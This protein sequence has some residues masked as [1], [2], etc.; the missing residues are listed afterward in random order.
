MTPPAAIKVTALQLRQDP[1]LLLAF[2]LG[3]G[4]SPRGPGTM[5]TVVAALIYAM[6]LQSAIW[7][8]QLVVIVVAGA[9]G[10]YLCDYACRKLV[11]HDHPGI[12]WDEWVGFWIAGF[13]LPDSFTALLIAF[14]LFRLLDIAKPWPIRWADRRIHGGLGVML[15]DILAGLGA[16]L[17]AHL[18]FWIYAS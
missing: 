12:V 18:A 9:L 10:V 15:D 14:G 6:L 11:V 17:L 2:G 4:L 1:R 16:M 5:G 3:A 13:A 8:V 7:W